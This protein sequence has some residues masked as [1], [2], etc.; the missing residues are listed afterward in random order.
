MNPR[1]RRGTAECAVIL[2]ATIPFGAQAA[3]APAF[4]SSGDSMLKGSYFARWV[5]V[6]QIDRGTGA[7]Q[8]ARSLTGTFSFDGA[9]HYSFTG[10]LSV[11]TQSSGAPSPSNVSS[12]TYAVSSAGLLQL[13]NPVDSTETLLGGLGEDA[14]VA[15]STQPGS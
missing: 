7:F 5:G 8:R 4:D 2:L 11:S 12:G 9:G 14:F 3:S 13:E 1:K 15:S 6:D 10:Q